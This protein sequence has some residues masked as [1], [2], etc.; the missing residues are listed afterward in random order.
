MLAT[1]NRAMM[2]EEC[3]MA[4]SSRMAGQLCHTRLQSWKWTTK[5]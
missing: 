4:D 5:Q 1:V 3:K 2:N